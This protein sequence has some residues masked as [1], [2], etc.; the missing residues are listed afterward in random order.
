MYTSTT[1]ERP[2]V[3]LFVAELAK[4]VVITKFNVSIAKDFNAEFGKVYDFV[5]SKLT[6]EDEE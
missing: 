4:H 1:T 2:A 5:L 3:E 6:E